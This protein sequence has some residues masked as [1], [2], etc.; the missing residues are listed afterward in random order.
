MGRRDVG[1]GGQRVGGYG[2]LH[3]FQGVAVVGPDVLRRCGGG[4]EEDEAETSERHCGLVSRRG[5][6][7]G[8]TVAECVASFGSR[9]RQSRTG[10]FSTRYYSDVLRKIPAGTIYL[11]TRGSRGGGQVYKQL[12]SNLYCAAILC[13]SE[14]DKQDG[15]KRKETPTT[16]RTTDRGPIGT[17]L[18]VHRGGHDRIWQMAR[19]YGVLQI[20]SV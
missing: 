7:G 4:S 2:I 12:R 14:L 1:G 17:H 19:P 13:K 9:R 20:T 3:T 10:S 8:S 11:T 6:L 16:G 15:R 5:E 18:W